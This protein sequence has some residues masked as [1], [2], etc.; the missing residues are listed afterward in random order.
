MQ[1]EST[2]FSKKREHLLYNQIS[3]LKKLNRDLVLRIKSYKGTD[4][5]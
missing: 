2:P 3:Q 1:Q 4:L 5:V